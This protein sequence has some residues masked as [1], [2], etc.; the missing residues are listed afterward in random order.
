M[1]NQHIKVIG[2]SIKEK[3]EQLNQLK[4]KLQQ[5]TNDFQL[6]LRDINEKD[7]QIEQ[8]KRDIENANLEYESSKQRLESSNILLQK[9]SERLTNLETKSSNITDSIRNI[10]SEILKYEFQITKIKE[11]PIQTQNLHYQDL[12]LDE[13]REQAE[14]AEKRLEQVYRLI[15]D[16]HHECKIQIEKVNED[17]RN[18]T[19]PLQREFDLLQSR[20]AELKSSIKHFEINMRNGL[21]QLEL[22]KKQIEAE[23]IPTEHYENQIV[24]LKN[25]IRR[26]DA[27]ID[28]LEDKIKSEKKAE[29][30]SRKLSEKLKGDL[31]ER[32]AQSSEQL[33]KARNTIGT[34]KKEITRIKRLIDEQN[35]R[36]NKLSC[37][38]EDLQQGREVKQ[39]FEEIYAQEK[40]ELDDKFEKLMQ[41]EKRA[42]DKIAAQ[43]R[44]VDAQIDKK[45]KELGILTEQINRCIDETRKRSEYTKKKKKKIKTL[46][47][48]IKQM[49]GELMNIKNDI[50][51][52]KER[53]KPMQVIIKTE[54]NRRNPKLHSEADNVCKK[55][56]NEEDFDIGEVE[57]LSNQ[58][59]QY[60][61]QFGEAQ[62]EMELLKTEEQT[63]LKEVE[64]LKSENACLEKGLEKFDEVLQYHKLLKENMINQQN[65]ES[66]EQKKALKKK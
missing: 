51:R 22:Q 63:I 47:I 32:M 11:T 12:E 21:E 4:Q 57:R 20:N 34:Q 3:D 9:A 50:E 13:L 61:K 26:V 49:E 44:E 17:M 58:I 10:K 52:E 43:Q 59:E 66:A 60:E 19:E 18:E 55:E 62:K 27:Q 65:S 23:V 46:V 33:L 38:L 30:Q 48:A 25:E 2:D 39:N 37:V 64:R 42:Q 6:N 7:N 16:I 29:E 8:L 24:D 35:E 45:K 53:N 14:D 36:N 54:D 40:A 31:D 56:G 41:K 5:L 28:D 15:E 1:D